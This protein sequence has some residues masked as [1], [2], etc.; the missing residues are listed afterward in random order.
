MK[1]SSTLLWLV[2]AIIIVSL[3]SC[4]IITAIE[5][6]YLDT[7]ILMCIIIIMLFSLSY[8]HSQLK[9]LKQNLDECIATQNELKALLADKDKEIAE[10]DAT[11]RNLFSNQFNLLDQLC[12]ICYENPNP[13]RRKEAVYKKVHDELELFSSNKEFLKKLENLVNKYNN[14]VMRKIRE[15][16]PKLSKMEFRLLSFFYAGFSAKAISMFTG[17]SLNNIYVKKTRLKHKIEEIRPVSWEEML[18]F[19]HCKVLEF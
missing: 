13:T 12:K 5:S 19:L 7:E 6:L 9:V 14:D 4:H 17:D 2:V 10:R 16:M 11:I 1:M 8:C 3:S 15:G 18:D